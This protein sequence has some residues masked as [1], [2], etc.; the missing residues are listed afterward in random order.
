MSSNPRDEH[1]S[2]Q[3][4]FRAIAEADLPLLH[5]WLT[6][7]HVAEHWD[8]APSLEAV[9]EDYL[10]RD[11][12]PTT[13]PLDAHSGAVQYLA[14]E[15]GVPF[16]YAQA[17]RVVASQTEGWWLEE[18]DPHALGVDLF[19]ADPGRLGRGLGARLVRAFLSLLFADPRVT[20]VQIDPRPE[21]TRA[22]ASFRKAG[23]EDVGLVDTPDGPVWLMRIARDG[24]SSKR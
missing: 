8:A 10:P 6:R 22:I 5:D 15:N 19:I 3:I 12:D 9:R 4:T 13:R 14:C 17:Y 16:G 23:F 20:T 24:A 2:P 21:N 7:P 11:T 1:A 18:R